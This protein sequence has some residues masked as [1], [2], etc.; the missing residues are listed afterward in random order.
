[1]MSTNLEIQEKTNERLYDLLMIKK[2]NGDFVN[3]R[4]DDAIARTK[5]AMTKEAIAWVEQ[6]AGAV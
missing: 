1:M 5:A 4:L 3:K 6:Q 2:D